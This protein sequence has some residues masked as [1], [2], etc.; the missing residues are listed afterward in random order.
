M[1]PAELLL[2]TYLPMTK[3]LLIS[4]SIVAATLVSMS[5]QGAPSISQTV[6]VSKPNIVLFLVDD[7]ATADVK[8]MRT[9]SRLARAGVRFSRFVAPTP[10]CAPSRA[11]ILRGQYSSNTHQDIDS[12][13]DTFHLLRFEKETI[14]VWLQRAGYTTGL[15]GKYI[16]GY[17]ESELV[18]TRYVPPGWNEWYGGPQPE[19][20]NFTLNENGTVVEYK[21]PGSPHIDDKLASLA[22]DFIDRHYSVP[23][24]LYIAS[25]SAHSPA[26]PA[27]RYEGMFLD[28]NSVP[29]SPSFNE[30][31]VSDKPAYIQKKPK[32]P[33]NADERL[34]LFRNRLRTLLSVED[35][36][37]AV[38]A[39]LTKHS[40][41]NNTYFVFVSDN[42]WHYGEHRITDAKF[43]PYEAANI[44][45]AWIWG[46]GIPANSSRDYLVAN[47]DL[48]QTFAEWAGAQV[49]SFVDGR[50]L[51]PLLR[52]EPMPI[53]EWRQA[54]VLSYQ[55]DLYYP[56]P[57]VHNPW[58][59]SYIG[60]LTTA[61]KYIHYNTSEREL[62]FNA[63]D[64]YEMESQHENPLWK[65]K[66]QKL[67]LWTRAFGHC[68]GET[69]RELDKAPPA[70]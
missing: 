67:L 8:Y 30:E 31:D 1:T 60:L 6:T 21:E 63:S 35:L 70:K 44:V 41:L 62:Y 25:T 5:T 59:P 22:V 14:A 61:E 29:Q 2:T 38:T 48:A 32:I 50:S 18:N 33:A 13:F 52:S 28:V 55:E 17:M 36:I 37:K 34:Q 56:F 7:M 11:S 66:M 54:L 20:Y 24:F 3:Y 15:F 39:A 51:V 40:V 45:P 57:N 69:C 10:W 64:P 16:N 53:S 46:P 23:M 27:H 9:L 47:S 19:G 42:G 65:N 43:T 26:V 4:L 49:P 12:G 58:P 68:R